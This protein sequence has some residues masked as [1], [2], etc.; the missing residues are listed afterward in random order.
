M[1]LSSYQTQGFYDEVFDSEGKDAREARLL[2]EKIESLED[3][4][5][6]RCQHAA[7]A[8]FCKWA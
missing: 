5:L 1:E 6:L 4:E 7:E 3:G 2:L 8:L